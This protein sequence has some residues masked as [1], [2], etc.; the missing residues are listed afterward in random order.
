[1]EKN[2]WKKLRKF[3][4][5]LLIRFERIDERRLIEKIYFSHIMVVDYCDDKK[6]DKAWFI[7]LLEIL[8]L[9]WNYWYNWIDSF[10]V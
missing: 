9:I 4:L 2:G 7:D 8:N 10:I 5:K 1:M 6:N 3:F